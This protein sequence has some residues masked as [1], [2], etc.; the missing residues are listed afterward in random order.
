M[1]YERASCGPSNEPHK[2]SPERAQSGGKEEDGGGE[3]DADRSWRRVARLP[4]PV[5]V[6]VPAPSSPPL[7]ATGPL[8]LH[9]TTTRRAR[10]GRPI[11]TAASDVTLLCCVCP[12][13]SP[14]RA[15]RRAG[16]MTTYGVLRVYAYGVHHGRREHVR[17][18]DRCRRSNG[19]EYV[20]V[21]PM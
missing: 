1:R 13:L 17:T 14:P 18:A 8:Q 7:A 6:P 5:P 10:A 2:I 11:E 4:A 20:R 21:H 9:G 19:G 16:R 12:S 3:T 15:R